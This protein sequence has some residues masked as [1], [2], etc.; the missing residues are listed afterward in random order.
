VLPVECVLTPHQ[1]KSILFIS[2]LFL[3]HGADFFMAVK[4]TFHYSL[5]EY[6]ANILYHLGILFLL[7][8]LILSPA[9][10]NCRK[11]IMYF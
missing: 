5:P 7:E 3:E 9:L 10:A 1:S 8:N 6:A 11:L 2:A 4:V